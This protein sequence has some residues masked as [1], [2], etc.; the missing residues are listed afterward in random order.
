M[1]V[2]PFDV[3]WIQTR[4]RAE[5]AEFRQV[6]QRGDLAA[7]ADDAIPAPAAFVML[8]RERSDKPSGASGGRYLA[9]VR[10]TVG[11]LIVAEQFRGDPEQPYTAAPALI[12]A[13]REALIGYGGTE[14]QTPLQLEGGQVIEDAADRLLWLDTYALDYWHDA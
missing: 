7:I 14:S 2:G 10:A 4:L 12:R 1:N 11:V 5:V 8:G 3:T 9:K 13:S 6:G